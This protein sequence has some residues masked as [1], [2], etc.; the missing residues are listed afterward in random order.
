MCRYRVSIGVLTHKLNN[1]H[2]RSKAVA[3]GAISFYLDNFVQAR[4]A[5]ETYGT[6]SMELYDPNDSEHA[7]R[8][9]K[10]QIM[11]SGQR[12]LEMFS[13][14]LSKVMSR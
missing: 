2:T 6:F 4:I 10:T 5:K 14:I 7:E 9:D 11:L 3:D 13:I 12:R 1:E 8:Q